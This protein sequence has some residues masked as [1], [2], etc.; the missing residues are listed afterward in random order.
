MNVAVML[1]GKVPVNLNF[2][3][4]RAAIDQRHP[5]GDIDRFLTADIFVRK[6][7]SFPWP[8]MQAAHPH[9][10]PAAQAEDQDRHLA[11]AQQDPAPAHCWPCC[12]AFQKRR[13]GEARCSSPAAAPGESEGRG[14]HPPQ[15]DGQ[16]HPVRQPPRLGAVTASSAA[17]R[18]STASAAPSRSGIRSSTACISSPTR[19]RWR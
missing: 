2:T 8:P 6:V 19:R 4:G 12:L 16:R 18:C 15:S 10:A 14:A 5:S 7:Q 11:R 13:Q 3:A 17:C 1:A 9:R